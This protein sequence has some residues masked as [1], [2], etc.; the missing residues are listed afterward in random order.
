MGVSG[1]PR[2]SIGFDLMAIEFQACEQ[3]TVG[4]ELEL[5]LLDAETLDL[6]DGIV[7]LIKLYPDREFVRPEFF[8]SCVEISSP[9]CA[10]TTDAQAHL[11]QTLS[12]LM[13]NCRKLGMTLCGGGTH[14]FDQRLALITPIRRFQEL[15]ASYG[16]MALTQLTFATPVHVGMPSGNTAIFVMRHLTPCLPALLAV[17][18]NSPYWRGYETGYASYRSCILAA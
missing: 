5:Q 1:K 12:G 14:T 3:A 10:N 7:P 17:A 9:P 6:M 2:G 13:A 15:E 4:I 18:A 8:Q 11:L 16:Y